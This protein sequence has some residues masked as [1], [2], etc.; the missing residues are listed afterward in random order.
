MRVYKVG[1]FALCVIILVRLSNYYVFIAKFLI[2]SRQ[3]DLFTWTSFASTTTFEVAR[4]N[5]SWVDCPSQYGVNLGAKPKL[6]IA[7]SGQLTRLELRSKLIN[8]VSVNKHKFELYAIV[9]LTHGQMA[10]T[11]YF[12]RCPG[13]HDTKKWLQGMV[14]YIRET[15]PGAS[16]IQTT[17]RY[18]KGKLTRQVF[19]FVLLDELQRPYLRVAFALT[20]DEPMGTVLLNKEFVPPSHRVINEPAQHDMFRN[21]RKTMIL[22]EQVELRLGVF[23]DYVFRVREDAFFLR[24][25]RLPDNIR[26]SEFY[27]PA[28]WTAG[29]YGDVSFVM[30]REVAS[31]IMRGLAEDYYLRIDKHY[32]NPE[33]FV[34]QLAKVYEANITK[35]NVC[36]WPVT[37]VIFFRGKGD[38]MMM[39]LRGQTRRSAMSSCDIWKVKGHCIWRNVSQIVNGAYI[40]YL[41]E[42]TTW[43]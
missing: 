39:K 4:G 2:L 35:V 38:K 23:F 13:P 1:V 17:R 32:K 30:G 19:W 5:C 14:L 10:A 28:C 24:P 8:L 36:E 21:I 37:P 33:G 25:F 3:Q 34:K 22:L 16:S 26:P 20:K 42:F 9:L 41:P 6:A 18:T 7:I 12:G 29:G 11:N 43:V 31:G 15:F 40:P 27:T